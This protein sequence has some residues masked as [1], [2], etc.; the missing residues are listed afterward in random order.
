MRTFFIRTINPI[1]PAKET[2]YRIDPAIYADQMQLKWVFAQISQAQSEYYVLHWT[3]NRENRVG[4]SGGMNRDQRTID[5]GRNPIED[6]VGF[7][8]WHREFVP[9]TQ[10]LFLFTHE[11]ETMELKLDTSKEEILAFLE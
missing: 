10:R 8:V 11:L 6:A 2:D 9:V 7:F 4:V 5:F 1:E 3:L